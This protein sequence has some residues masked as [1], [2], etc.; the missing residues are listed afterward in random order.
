MRIPTQ[1]TISKG[2]SANDGT[3]DS[4]RDAADKI[5]D[6]FSELWQ[7]TYNSS[8]KWPGRSFVVGSVDTAFA[9]PSAGQV[10]L[11]SGV[12]LNG[13][14]GMLMNNINQFRISQ[15]DQ[16]GEKRTTT[17]QKNFNA[18]TTPDQ[19]DSAPDYT[20][21][22]MYKRQDSNGVA[23]TDKSLSS[24]KIVGI[25]DGYLYYKTISNPILA[26]GI[27]PTGQRFPTAYK[28]KPH[29]SDYWY[30][31][32]NTPPII[33]GDSA[34]STGDSCFIKIENYW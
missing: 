1:K 20:T 23:R 9:E 12:A 14:G 29:D 28:F 21:L 19:Y 8:E 4:L 22:T 10:T 5:N 7:S 2:A 15:S 3:G 27:P 33:Y 31:S 6:N 16:L 34:V 13:Q 30:F 32:V 26:D 24:Y 25:Y 17:V 18:A 11:Y